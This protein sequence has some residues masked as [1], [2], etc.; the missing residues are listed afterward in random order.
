MRPLPSMPA[1]AS[2][3]A[4]SVASV[5]VRSRRVRPEMSFSRTWYFCAKVRGSIP[6][7]ISR[8]WSRCAR[9]CDRKCRVS[10]F[11]AGLRAADCPAQPASARSEAGRLRRSQQLQS[12]YAQPQCIGDDTYRRNGDRGSSNNRREQDTETRIEDARGNRNAG[13]VVYKSEEQILPDVVHGGP[14]EA[15]RANDAAQIA[16]QER[17]VSALHR[18]VGDGSHGDAD[19]RGGERRGVVDAVSGHRDYSPC[20][21]QLSDHRALL[22]RK[23]LR[24]DI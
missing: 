5:A 20:L 3:M 9:S 18:D 6:G 12:G 4:R 16:F 23:H 8:S 15:A 17:N 13:G 22:I 10:H 11:M 2:S 1:R 19:F 14:R 7:S 24:L 21:L